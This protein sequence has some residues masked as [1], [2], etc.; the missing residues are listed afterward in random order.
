MSNTQ[1]C[2][3]ADRDCPVHRGANSCRAIATVNLYRVDWAD[4]S[5]VAFCKE[6]EPVW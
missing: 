4:M 5:P 1:E 3:C 2:Q 6:G